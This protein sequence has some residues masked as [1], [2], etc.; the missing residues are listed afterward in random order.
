MEPNKKETKRFLIIYCIAIFVF[1]VTLILI[2]SFSQLRITREA[3]E[4]KE[5]L[6][7]AEILAAD[8]Q[9]RLD[10]V[11]TENSRLNQQIKLLETSKETLTAENE[12]LK[13][14]QTTDAKRIAAYQKLAEIIN[15]KRLNKKSSLR[16]AITAFEEGGY[17]ECLNVADREVYNSIK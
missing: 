1:A 16:N 5:R 8:K 13:E 7:S 3:D 15:Y 14:Q 9:T 12:K 17:A 10:A 11:M 4:I 6:S 2:A